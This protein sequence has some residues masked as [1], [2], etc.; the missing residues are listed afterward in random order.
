MRVAEY[1][2]WICVREANEL[3][4]VNHTAA[5]HCN[6]SVGICVADIFHTSGQSFRVGIRGEVAEARNFDV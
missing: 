6:N 3:R 5:T 4:H 1:I 2:S